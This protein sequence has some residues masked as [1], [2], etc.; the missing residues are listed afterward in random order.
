[1]ASNSYATTAVANEPDADKPDANDHIIV[2]K[3][4]T[5]FQRL[6]TELR[7]MVYEFAMA[8]EK[9][10]LVHLHAR[11]CGIRRGHRRRGCPRGYGL[12]LKIYDAQ[13][14]QVPA[15]FF[16]NYECRFLAL[17][18]YSIRFS[19]SQQYRA[20]VLAPYD[21]RTTNIIMS[22]NDIL[23]SWHTEELLCH[24]L[25]KFNI[26]FG[27]GA[28]LVR[29][30]I[31]CPWKT[32]YN[33]MTLEM[34]GNLFSKLNNANAIEKV[35]LLRKRVGGLLKFGGSNQRSVD[36]HLY[37][38]AAYR[39]FSNDIAKLLGDLRNANRPEWLYVDAEPN[40]SNT[41]TP[42]TPTQGTPQTARR[43]MQI[44]NMIH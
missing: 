42:A 21:Q 4:F 19:V 26:R 24:E 10:R 5:L 7:F 29:N 34:A 8:I 44:S 9:P 28:S 38:M 22:P 14:E 6:P 30:I 1:M 27:P 3:V 37:N 43:V 39:I 12:R 23:V 36:E 2:P 15:Y 16:V 40:V 11:G 20:E 17:K 32:T 33:T 13:Y 25:D 31:V 41:R 35:Y 18:H